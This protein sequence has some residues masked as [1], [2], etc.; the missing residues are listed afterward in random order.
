MATSLHAFYQ[1]AT[2]PD[3]QLDFD[4]WL[5]A[6]ELGYQGTFQEY[7]DMFDDEGELV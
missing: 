7:Q 6:V 5:Q 4:A 2:T 3:E 1:G